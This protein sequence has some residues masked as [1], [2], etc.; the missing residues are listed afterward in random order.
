M[1]QL[2]AGRAVSRGLS[3]P[4]GTGETAAYTIIPAN[5]PAEAI[6]ISFEFKIDGGNDDEF[7][8]MGVGNDEQYA[9]EAKYVADG[10]WNATPV[11]ALSGAQNTDSR[12]IF[13]MSG[14]SA[15]PT[16]TLTVRNIQFFLP[17]KPELRLAVSNN[18]LVASWLL[19]ALNWT[20]EA[21]DN[22]ANSNAWQTVGVVPMEGEYSRSVTL[23]ITGNRSSSS[24][25]ESS[26]CLT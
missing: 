11:I 20:L 13:A 2:R 9:M 7:M 14:T 4:L 6:G 21:N 23:D 12:L 8:A 1:R 10:E 16:G 18:Q 5:I 3:N 25:F 24:D 19:S 26:P 15:P 22:I 17:P